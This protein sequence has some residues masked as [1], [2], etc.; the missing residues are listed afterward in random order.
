MFLPI[1]FIL[2]T[3]FFLL[4]IDRTITYSYEI[5]LYSKKQENKLARY[6]LLLLDLFKMLNTSGYASRAVSETLR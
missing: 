1:V 2:Y 4:Y 5:K 3:L 6:I